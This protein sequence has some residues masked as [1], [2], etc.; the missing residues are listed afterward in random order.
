MMVIKMDKQQS[1]SD[2]EYNCKK[3]QTRKEIFLNAMEELIPWEEWLSFIEP[4][5]P[6]AGNGRPPINMEVMLRMYLVQNWFNLSDEATE[7]SIYDVQ[8]IRQFVGVNLSEENAPDATTLLHFRHLLEA[9]DLAIKMFDAIKNALKYNGYM[10][11]QGTIVDAAIISAPSSTKNKEH[12]RDPEMKSTKKGNNYY[13]G[14]KGHIGVDSESGF[15]HTLETTAA[16]EADITVAHKLLHGKEIFMYGDA[17]YVGVEK[18]GEFSGKSELSYQI[19]KRRSTLKKLPECQQTDE[20]LYHEKE[21]SSIR[22]KVELPF[23]ILKNIFKFKKTVYRGLMKNTTRLHM[24]FA[25][26]NLY[27]CRLKGVSLCPQ[28]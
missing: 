12:V 25:L 20:L 7:D 26:A 1:F 10:M 21:K 3:K 4:Y 14:M 6:K 5:Y 8:S 15:I 23:H 22:A 13:F 27:L 19:N 9:N 24:L 11:T 28:N 2:I 17:G 18:R 16:N